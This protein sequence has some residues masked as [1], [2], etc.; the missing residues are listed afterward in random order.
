MYW[1]KQLKYFKGLLIPLSLFF[2][3]IFIG[4]IGYLVI[5]EYSLLEALYMTVITI[6]TVGFMEVRPLSDAGRIFTIIIILINVGAFTF[7]VTYLTRYLLD[8]EFLRT[9]KQMKMD[10]AISQL[11]IM[12]LYVASVAT[13]Q[14]V[15]MC[16][17]ETEFL[18]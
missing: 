10:N 8:G 13:V 14:S 16:C 9:F 15:L 4:T 1:L 18:L 2:S 12:L 6:A 5:E 3:L 11:K 17:I 7:F